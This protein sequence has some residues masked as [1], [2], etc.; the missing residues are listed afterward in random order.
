[1]YH[2]I[3]D[4]TVTPSRLAVAPDVFADQLAYLR[5]EGFNAITAGELS[6]ILAGAPGDLPERPVVLTFDDGYGDF[7]SQGLPLLKQ[8]GFTGTIFMTTGWIGKEDER[9]RMLN[10]REL[11]EVEQAGIE[12][13]AHTCKHPQLDQLPENL[14]REELYVSKSLLED[15]L[16]LPVPGLAYPFGYSNAKVRRVTRELGY[17]YAYS[18]DN[19]LSTSAA[20]AFAIPRLT[21]KRITTMTD[22][23]KMVSGQ[24][25]LTLKRDRILTSGFSVVRR[26]KSTLQTA[27]KSA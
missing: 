7:Y 13:G 5:D 18:V 12:I 8:H 24:D 25:T 2:E 15:N 4:I 17:A 10:W 6:K 1:M 27:R 20:N 14:I 21:V 3:A 16:G 23:R 11:A 19:A 26:A 9:K 22:F